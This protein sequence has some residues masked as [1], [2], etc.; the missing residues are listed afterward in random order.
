MTDTHSLA[1]VSADLAGVA[2]GALRDSAL[3]S[4]LLIAAAGAA[5]LSAVGAP[6]VHVSNGGSVSA[7]LLVEPCHMSVHSLPQRGILL[8][9]VMARDEA[10]ATKALDVFVRRL[11]PASVARDARQR[12]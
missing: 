5:G 9:D 4:G 7:L 12:G 10:S 3:L 1:H 8:L 6:I 2:S 11:S